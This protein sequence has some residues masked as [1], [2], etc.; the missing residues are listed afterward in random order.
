MLWEKFKHTRMVKIASTYAVVGWVLLQVIEAILP[1]F[2]APEWIAQSLVFAIIL[3]FPVALLLVWATEKNESA[4][5]EEISESSSVKINH[6]NASESA[7]FWGIAAVSIVI[8]GLIAFLIMPDFSTSQNSE[9]SI[10][11][12]TVPL[13]D[14]ILKLK[15]NLGTTG[16]RGNA[17]PSE[18]AISPDGAYV[19]YTVFYSPIQHLNLRD[20]KSFEEDRV[21]VSLTLN[22][23][24]GFPLFSHDSQWVYYFEN[25]AIK[26]VRIEGGPPQTIIENSAMTQGL[27]LNSTDLF[28]TNAQDFGLYKLNI[29]SGNEQLIIGGNRSLYASYPAGISET[30]HILVTQ[31]PLR[32]YENASIYLL[33]LTTG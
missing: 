26:R 1:T 9:K 24:S 8:A 14:A 22:Q 17:G 2:N 30:S 11:E 13:N 23:T 27:I 33:D 7:S 5:S 29:S 12:D 25:S 3:G 31:S 28:F 19:I 21:L 15:L 18:I 16:E 4:F 10:L 32:D 6:K 20:L